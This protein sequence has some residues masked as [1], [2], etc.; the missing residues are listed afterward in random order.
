MAFDFYPD[1]LQFIAE[2]N[3]EK[4]EVLLDFHSD[5]STRYSYHYVTVYPGDKPDPNPKPKPKKSNKG[6]IIGV[7]VTAGVL[8]LA[9]VGFFVWKKMQSGGSVGGGDLTT[10]FTK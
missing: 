2:G 9:A 8:V 10:G 6:W 1:T 3:F 7:S 4:T 5:Y